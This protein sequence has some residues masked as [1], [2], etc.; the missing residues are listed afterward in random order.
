M[1]DLDIK[2]RFGLP[3][4]DLPEHRRR[5]DQ[6]TYDPDLYPNIAAIHIKSPESISRLFFMKR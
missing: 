4:P 6:N 3:P 5:D 2:E 1:I